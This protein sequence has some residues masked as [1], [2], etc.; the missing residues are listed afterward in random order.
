V[1]ACVGHLRAKSVVLLGNSLG[2]V[3][4]YQFAARRP[5][6]IRGLI[7]EDI[8]AEVWDDISFALAWEA[9]FASREGLEERVGLRLLPYLQDSFRETPPGWKLAFDPCDMVASQQ[10]L[11][12]DHW[13]DWLATECPALVIRG[14]DSRVTTQAAAEQMVSRRPSTRLKTLDGGHVVHADNPS[15]FANAVREFLSGL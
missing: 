7:V 4:A 9:Q 15:S 2:G 1:E 5:Q 12:G 6:R 14:S 10:S 8:G 3:N 11:L 13:Q